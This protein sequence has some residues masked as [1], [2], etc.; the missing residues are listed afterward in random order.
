M[1]LKTKIKLSQ[2]KKAWTQYVTIPSALVQDSQYPFKGND[3]LY[4]EVEPTIGIMII[5]EDAKQLKVTPEGVLVMDAS[6]D[7]EAELT[8]THQTRTKTN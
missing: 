5:S 6:A 2:S 4:L 8:V 7:L 3:E 1:V